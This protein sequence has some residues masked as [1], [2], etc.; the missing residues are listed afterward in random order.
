LDINRARFTTGGGIMSTTSSRWFWTHE[1]QRGGP[2]SWGELQS[3]ARSGQLRANYLVMREGSDR[4]QPAHTATETDIGVPLGGAAPP[5]FTP[6]PRQG[7][8]PGFMPGSVADEQLHAGPAT[9]G[10]ASTGMMLGGAL[11]C[12]LGVIGTYASYNAAA[13]S[14]TGGRYYIFTGPIVCGLAMFLRSFTG[15]RRGG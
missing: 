12:A 9:G 10:G 8:A 1:G 2:I 6:A 3:M 14:A 15:H 5:A 11:L 7:F 4:W 13:Q